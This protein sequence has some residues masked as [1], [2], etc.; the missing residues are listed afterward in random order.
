MLNSP[1]FASERNWCAGARQSSHPSEIHLTAEY[2]DPHA[3]TKFLMYYS[4]STSLTDSPLL[5]LHQL[6]GQ[7]VHVSFSTVHEETG[8]CLIS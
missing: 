8:A 7:S 2:I 3:F 4:V 6:A 1:L 5:V